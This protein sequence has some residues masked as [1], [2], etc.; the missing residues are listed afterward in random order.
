MIPDDLA[1]AMAVGFAEAEAAAG[2]RELGG[3]NRGPFVQKYL[4]AAHPE[5]LSHDGE[6]WCVA[7]YCWC[8]LQVHQAS[9]YALPFSFT[10]GVD[11]L[12]AMFAARGLVE[13]ASPPR[14]EHQ[15]EPPGRAPLAAPGDAAFFDWNRDGDPDHVAMVHRISPDGVLFTIG[16]NEGNEASGA[17]VRSK[18]RGRLHELPE[19]YGFGRVRT[20]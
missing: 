9:G 2:A 19:L 13:R 14:P 10:R 5:R 11:R 4:N 15:A 7:F 3:N 20:A 17:P 16:G 18:R 6:P 12:W 1:A 8:W